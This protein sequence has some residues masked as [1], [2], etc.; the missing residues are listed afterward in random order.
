MVHDS[1]R[2]SY[3]K[4][5]GMWVG[6]VV[7][8]VFAVTTTFLDWPKER[9]AAVIVAMVFVALI[10]VIIPS[11]IG[12]MFDRFIAQVSELKHALEGFKKI[13][14]SLESNGA[15]ICLKSSKSRNSETLILACEPYPGQPPAPPTVEANRCVY[16]YSLLRTSHHNNLQDLML[17][18]TYLPWMHE[19]S[20]AVQKQTRLLILPNELRSD[21][22]AVAYFEF[23]KSL[24]IDSYVYDKREFYEAKKA[25]D[26]EEDFRAMWKTTENLKEV[27]SKPKKPRCIK[28]AKTILNGNPNFTVDITSDV[29]WE[30]ASK[31]LP[32]KTGNTIC[33]DVK[34]KVGDDPTSSI[35]SLKCHD[36]DGKDTKHVALLLVL[37]FIQIAQ[38]S[39]WRKQNKVV[40]HV[41]SKQAN[42]ENPLNRND[43]PNLLL[44]QAARFQK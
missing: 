25:F 32:N 26:D 14:E 1:E 36:F 9:G 40:T 31:S 21:A 5:T 27:S 10:E 17:S 7:G 41:V 38:S 19:C 39:E 28:L 34:Y 6:L 30:H 29:T 4:R 18:P 43:L 44:Q 22:V 12:F 13:R 24:K 11:L 37:S 16:M 8:I 33:W 35:E 2:E 15:L 20:K 42:E 23:S 3:K